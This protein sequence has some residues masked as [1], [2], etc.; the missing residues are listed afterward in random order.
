[1]VALSALAIALVADAQPAPNDR[2]RAL[3]RDPAL[4]VA[5]EIR[6]RV[7][8]FPNFRGQVPHGVFTEDPARV[9]AVRATPRC[10]EE[11]DRIT[12][13]SPGFTHE[14]FRTGRS[15]IPSPVR[16]EG[17]LLGVSFRKMR[18]GAPFIVSCELAARLP[19]VAAVLRDHRIAEVHVLSSWR[20]EPRTSFHTMGMALDLARFVRDDGSVLDV[21]HDY[22]MHPDRPTCE[23]IDTTPVD[24]PAH[25]LEALACDLAARAGLSTV[26]TPDYSEGHRDHFHIDVR[27][28]DPRLFVR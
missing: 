13:Q 11:L 15:P 17:N 7:A 3:R 21:E 19:R 1:M 4:A 16:L 8:T 28:D 9:F 12:A 5:R 26:I 24:D 20:L 25:A 10:L 22:P 6:R 14:T 23:G 2:A 27:P 18:E